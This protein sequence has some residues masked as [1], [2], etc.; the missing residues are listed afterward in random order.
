MN[1]Y[2]CIIGDEDLVDRASIST[3]DRSREW[4]NNIASCTA[5]REY[6][7]YYRIFADTYVLITPVTGGYLTYFSELMRQSEKGYAQT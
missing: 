5:T 4:Q 2:I 6:V 7:S 3:A 1:E